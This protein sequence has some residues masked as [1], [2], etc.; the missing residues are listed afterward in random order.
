MDKLVPIGCK[1]GGVLSSRL[2][3]YSHRLKENLSQPSV[4]FE[5]MEKVKP[6]VIIVKVLT[7]RIRQGDKL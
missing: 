6:A 2:G 7:R 3:H 5:N 1:R 4:D